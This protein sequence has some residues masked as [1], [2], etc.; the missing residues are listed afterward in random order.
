MKSYTNILP[1]LCHLWR[2]IAPRRRKQLAL[3]LVIMV[4]A[5]LAEVASIGMV[6]PFLGALM[7]PERVFEHFMVQPIVAL[8]GVT[9]VSQLILP[10]TILFILSV[11]F[12]GAMRLILLWSQTRLGHAIGSDFSIQIYQSTLFQPYSV[13][14]ARNS[15]QVVDGISS[16]AGAV[17][18]SALLP[19]LTIVSSGA[20]LISV[21][22]VLLTINPVIAS[23]AFGAFGAIYACMVL[24]TRSRLMSYSQRISLESTKAL[25]VLQE[26]LGGIRDVLIDGT[27]AT[28]CKIYQEAELALR[29]SQANVQIIAGAPRFLIE[30]LGM[31]LIAILAYG[32][33]GPGQG[34]ASVIPVL[35]AL[36]VG[37]QR[38]LPVLQQLYS[39]W[40][41]I[42]GGQFS[43]K[44]VLEL[45]DQPLPKYA[46]EPLPA[47]I[48]FQE[49][50]RLNQIGFRYVESGPWVLQGVTLEIPKGNR[51]GFIGTTG[52]GKSTM[53][54]VLMGLL[55][56]TEGSLAID[57]VSIT[58]EN[59]RAWQAHI[60][61]VPQT[62]FLADTTIAE[63]IAFG[64]PP[65]KIDHERV[66]Y[67]ARQAQIAD[68]IESWSHQYDTVVGE[69]GIRL[70]GGQRQRI[71]IARAL[72]KQ[73]D[74]IV[75]DEATSAL[76]NETENAVMQAIE[77]IG[78]DITILI[79]A[80]RLTT[81]KGCD[82]IVE[83]EQGQ[84]KRIVGSAEIISKEK[85]RGISL[86]ATG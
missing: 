20:I 19:L 26:G 31:A 53:L 25:K 69:R 50:I 21:L 84:V 15:S 9:T 14:V 77:S 57:G 43:L 49:S 63:N 18:H 75:F 86:G 59:Y 76:D 70:S 10:L 23:V 82:R 78:K 56:P 42:R 54:D 8:L 22:I 5:S 29:R 72:Y 64:I 44:D 71:G 60:A 13:H 79:V 61:H 12:A 45:L 24:A 33:A 85:L 58:A 51:I 1:L 47:P 74:V 17:V 41:G 34:I 6:L 16:K 28:Y 7:S 68:T 81:L 2:H 35:G 55:P 11:L 27:Q 66:K 65:E 39:S 48:S 62:I 3:L 36:V 40:S 73:A 37:A 4:L 32:F 46:A 67:A 30:S 52:S 38:M 80:H 83:L